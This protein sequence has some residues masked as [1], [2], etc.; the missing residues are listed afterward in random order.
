MDVPLYVSFI[1][2]LLPC[3][4]ISLNALHIVSS[5]SGL[6]DDLTLTFFVLSPCARGKCSNT[7]PSSVF[8]CHSIHP[9]T[10][11]H[12]SYLPCPE[13]QKM[14]I[15]SGTR[16]M[17]TATTPAFCVVAGSGLFKI[18]LVLQGEYCCLSHLLELYALQ[19][20]SFVFFSTNLIL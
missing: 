10:T 14:L 4:D 2:S 12:D 5:I 19:C 11:H 16:Q 8:L 1:L 7:Q 9:F 18:N 3:S 17:E 6:S 15:H 13:Q 20:P